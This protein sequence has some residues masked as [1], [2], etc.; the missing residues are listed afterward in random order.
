MLLPVQL[1]VRFAESVL[2]ESLV[3]GRLAHLESVAILDLE[4]VAMALEG[5]AE[6]AQMAQQSAREQV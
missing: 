2:L 1:P 3:L 5:L 6:M 4:S